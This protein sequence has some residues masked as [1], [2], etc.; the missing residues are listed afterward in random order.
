VNEFSLEIDSDVVA[1]PEALIVRCISSID[2]ENSL[3]LILPK[4]NKWRDI[5]MTEAE[6][7]LPDHKTYDH[8]MELKDSQ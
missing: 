7:Q 5:M 2:D 6:R 8:A 3:S 1:K 4:F